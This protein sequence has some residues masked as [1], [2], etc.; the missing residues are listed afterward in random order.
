MFGLEKLN[1]A[2]GMVEF[3]RG[4]ANMVGLPLI[5]L[6]YDRTHS[7]FWPFVATGSTLFMATAIGQVAHIVHAK[8]TKKKQA[9][10]QAFILSESLALGNPEG[11]QISFSIKL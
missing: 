2:F 5:G 7:Y 4:V 3:F 11:K 1:E 9:L 10:K 6:L 8:R